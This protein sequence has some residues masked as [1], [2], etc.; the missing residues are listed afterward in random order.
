MDRLN[1]AEQTDRPGTDDGIVALVADEPSSELSRIEELPLLRAPVRL[2]SETAR[3]YVDAAYRE[4]QRA[5]HSF[6]LH[7]SRDTEAAAD[8]TQE[9]F[10][11]LLA[12]VQRAGVPDNVRA[13][14]F[15]VTANLAVSRGRRLAVAERWL[16]RFDRS[17]DMVESP[18]ATLLQHEHEE[19]VRRALGAVPKDARTCLL[20]AA[21]GFS[22]REIADAIGRSE[23]ATRAL[24]CR[25]RIRLRETLAEADL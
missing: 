17:R 7:A 24:I 18:E 13:W 4:H 10:I 11:R 3:A 14:L 25:A 21:N 16:H 9:A 1:D 8:L 22:G 12:E 5:V 23:L 6:A 2:G 15:R 19:R 20:M